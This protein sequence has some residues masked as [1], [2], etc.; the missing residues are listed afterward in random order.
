MG[1]IGTTTLNP[2]GELLWQTFADIWRREVWD[3]N[4]KPQLQNQ[5]TASVKDRFTLRATTQ[6]V[7]VCCAYWMRF[8]RLIRCAHL[9][10][11]STFTRR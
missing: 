11:R 10:G 5:T 2:S 8:P 9:C 6:T 3:G 1:A 4:G 7:C